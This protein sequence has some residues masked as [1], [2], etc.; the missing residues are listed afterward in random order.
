MNKNIIC[1]G[2]LSFSINCKIVTDEALSIY[3]LTCY[4]PVKHKLRLLFQKT[5]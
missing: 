3:R 5:I 4:S 2:S 1:T